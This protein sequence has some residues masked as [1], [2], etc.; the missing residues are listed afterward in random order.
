MT[1]KILSAH[2]RRDVS[3]GDLA[4]ADVDLFYMQDGTAPLAVQQFKELGIKKVPKPDRTVI[5]IDHTSP[6]PRA[7]LSNTQKI[8]RQFAR[9]AGIHLFDV[10]SGISHQIASERFFRP[11]QISVAADSHTCTG[12]ALGSA[13]TGMGS[14]DVAVAMAL[15]E[16]WFRVPEAVKVEMTGRLQR[17]VYAKDLILFLIGKIGADG[18]NY[19]SLEWVGDGVDRLRMDERLTIANMAIECG[20]KFGL[21]PSDKVTESYLKTQ[22]RVEDF[23]PVGPDSAAKYSQEVGINAGE[24][25]PMVAKPHT[26]DKVVPVDEVKGTK[27]DQAFIGT[28]TNARIEDLEIAARI[29]KGQ[30]RHPDTRL[31]VTPAS[32]K[33]WD[34]A[35][36]R[37]YLKVFSEAGAVITSSG[38][39][40]CVG[41][42]EGVLGDG[43]VCLSTMN[44]NFKGR[45]G[46]PNSF[47][48]LASPATVAASA[49]KGE[50]SDPR[51]FS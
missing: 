50:I 41:I 49:V 40:P 44:R 51:E 39:G 35:L 48:Y 34:E 22:G 6:S 2:A 43:E 21:F 25:S 18:A 36:E 32:R 10:G 30:T 13:A 7:E 5:F 12:G 16:T 38:C 11:G 33:V 47:I 26:V 24:L 14:T 29:L 37:G 46:N 3:A 27:I 4:V 8:L 45:M 15:G 20:A 31:I 9:E 19:K 28:C 17:E 23:Q 1:E 42:H